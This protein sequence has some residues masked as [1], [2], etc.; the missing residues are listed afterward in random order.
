VTDETIAFERNLA[1]DGF[2]YDLAEIGIRCE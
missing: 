1:E 2:V